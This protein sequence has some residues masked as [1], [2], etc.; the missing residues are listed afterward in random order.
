MLSD[1]LDL[2]FPR[3]CPACDAVADVS[4]R[5]CPDCLPGVVPAPRHACP[6]CG[7]PAGHDGP[8]FPCVECRRRPPP[9]RRAA[10]AF[11]FGGSLADAL[12]RFKSGGVPDFPDAV[13][14]PF[15]RAVARLLA[16]DRPPL[17][18]HL[19]VAVPPDPQRLARRGF[20]PA[21]LVIR[22]A[23][24]HLDLRLAHDVLRS[25]PRPR[26]QRDLD[27]DARL[28]ALHGVFRAAP[29]AERRLRGR[30]VLLLDD[31]R[32]TGSTVAA[33]AR[34]LLAAGAASVRVATLALVE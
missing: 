26:P 1:L 10:A 21:T 9:F 12:A 32:T 11:L 31:V 33:C 13:A 24:R 20:D 17:P 14:A 6:V 5:F 25:G 28:R 7:A 2:L 3:R 4:A 29:G 18:V 27:R 23:L 34:T 22:A 19:A 15:A 8:V 16:A 30:H